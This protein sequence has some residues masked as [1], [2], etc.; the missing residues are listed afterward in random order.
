MTFLGYT[1]IRVLHKKKVYI[2]AQIEKGTFLIFR[3]APTKI[4]HVFSNT[5]GCI[6]QETNKHGILL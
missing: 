3:N 1:V 2:F 5:K 6:K 4:A